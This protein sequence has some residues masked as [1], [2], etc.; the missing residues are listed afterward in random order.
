MAYETIITETR[1]N[2]LLL[3]LNRPE[4][5]NALNSKMWEELCDAI[6]DFDRDDSLA[7]M[8]ITN[9]GK[10]FCS[11]TDLKELA[12]GEYHPPRG[13]ED[14][15]FAGMTRHYVS[16]PVIAAVNGIAVGGGA[17]M[18]VAADLALISDD[19]K[20]GFPEIKHSLLATGGGALLRMGRSMYTKRAMELVLTGDAID[21]RTALE[22]GLVNHVVPAEELV[23]RAIELAE[24]IAKNG[25]IAIRMTKLALYDCM[26]KSFLPATDGWRMMADFDAAIK[27][28][29][30]SKEGERAFAEKREPVWK[31]R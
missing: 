9:T 13:R 23:D 7:V 3:T 25:P 11:G 5:R 19:G 12:R 4:V 31:N 17:E 8:V 14:W 24:R 30:D 1:G 10:C 20:I 26:D 27:R 18:V 2:V 21:A 16:K 28:T 15:G 22:W 29:E 6:D